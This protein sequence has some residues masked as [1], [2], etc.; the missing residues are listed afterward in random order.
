ME[1][2]GNIFSWG[3]SGLC[4]NKWPK[5]THYEEDSIDLCHHS[6]ADL[7]K[8]KIYNANGNKVLYKTFPWTL[9]HVFLIKQV[10][11]WGFKYEFCSCLQENG[12]CRLICLNTWCPVNGTVLE[13]LGGVA[14]GEACLWEWAVNF[15]KLTLF[16]V[17]CLYVPP[18]CG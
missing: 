16:P 13:G 6:L 12:P 10:F 2:P 9:E 5:I 1:M 3:S 14:L 7:L 8:T 17:I 15:Q 4:D 11:Q 18:A